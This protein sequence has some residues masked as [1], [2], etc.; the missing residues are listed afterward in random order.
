MGVMSDKWII[1]R[2]KKGMIEPF[3]SSQVGRGVISFGVSS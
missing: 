1:S 3:E 2:A